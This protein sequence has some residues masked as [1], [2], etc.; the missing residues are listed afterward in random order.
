MLLGTHRPKQPVAAMDLT[1]QAIHA[2]GRALHASHLEV[3][4][5]DAS[6]HASA[7][8]GRAGP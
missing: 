5:N 7:P 4:G 6:I 3:H 1:S 8:V 2:D